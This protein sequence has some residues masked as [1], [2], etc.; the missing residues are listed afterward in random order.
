MSTPRREGTPT[1]TALMTT[2]VDAAAAFYGGLLGWRVEVAG[3]Q[4]PGGLRSLVGEAAVATLAAVPRQPDGRETPVA[5]VVYLAVDDIGTTAARVR[6]AGGTVLAGPMEVPGSGHLAIV[7]D[8]TGAGF[9]LWQSDPFVGAQLMDAPGALVWCEVNTRDTAR[10]GDFYTTVFGYD[11][12]AMGGD[13]FRYTT[14]A[15]GE[16]PV[17]GMLGMDAS[18]PEALPPQSHWMTYFAVTD[19]DAAAA[20]ARELGGEVVHGPFDSQF[21]RIAVVQD[22]Q[23]G[24]LA[25][26]TPATG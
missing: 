21:G 19:T 17:C 24:V 7:T 12:R 5:W 16:Q 20:R 2:D 14:F 8:P 4:G 22:P 6:T 11:L 25:V 26:M 10:A 23:G 1:W 18:W 9:G 13:E 3:D 15:F